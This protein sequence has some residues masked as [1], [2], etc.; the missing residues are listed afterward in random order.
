LGI[1][2]KLRK[3]FQIIKIIFSTEKL[4][5]KTIEQQMVSD[6]DIGTFLSGGVDSSLITALA[7][8]LKSKNL[9][10]FTLGI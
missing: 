10:T 9:K 1:K 2:S 3:N 5:T 6:V 7:G 4:L 8:K